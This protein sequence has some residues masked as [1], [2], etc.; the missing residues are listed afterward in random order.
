MVFAEGIE[1]DVLDR[2]H[3]VVVRGEEGAIDDLLQA[4][5]VAVAEVAHGLGG[6]LGRIAQAFAVRVLAQTQE[7]LPIVPAQLVVHA[8]SPCGR[9][10]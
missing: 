8:G 3:L 10:I 5:G 2:H 4:L 7:D 9:F 6:A 1:L